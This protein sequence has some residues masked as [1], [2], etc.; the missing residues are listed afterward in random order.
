M[1][2]ALAL[3]VSAAS[4]PA[5][6]I[7]RDVTYPAGEVTAKGY[8]ATPDDGGKH[9]GVLIIHEWWGQNEYTR[10]RAR[11]LAE[12]GY[13]ALAVDMYGDGKTASHPR[14]AGTYA[15]MVKNNQPEMKARFRGAMKFLRA[16]DAVGP[17]QV[18]AIGYSF[19]G[20]VVLQMAR[21]GQKNLAGVASFHGSL[22]LRDPNPP[23][24]IKA[25]VLV[26]NGAEDPFVRPAEIEQF[27]ELMKK[28]K[29]DHQFINYPGAFHA[30]TNKSAT[31]IGEQSGLSLQYNAKADQA[32]WT[33]LTKF[34]AGLFKDEGGEDGDDT[35]PE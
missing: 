22:S 1:L 18:A 31:E 8:L 19:G 7:T 23:A 5:G 13:T 16:Q 10:Q 11:M 35:P 3:L 14:D 30:F 15:S 29:V 9:P 12:L 33:E 34:L 2:S 21:N 20:N 25:K 4:G 26:C 28:H 32:S 17:D 24:R 6:I 27:K